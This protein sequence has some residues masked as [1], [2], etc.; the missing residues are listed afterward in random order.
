MLH[1]DNVLTLRDMHVGNGFERARPNG[2]V[3]LDVRSICFWSE[4]ACAVQLS[5][6]DETC[7]PLQNTACGC[8]CQRSLQDFINETVVSLTIHYLIQGMDVYYGLICKEH[9]D[10]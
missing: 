2:L 3:L 5:V 10:L 8:I 1:M 7:M 9:N 4:A 6:S